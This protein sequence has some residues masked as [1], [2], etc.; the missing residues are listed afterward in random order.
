MVTKDPQQ[1]S[2]A[3]YS[4]Q[5]CSTLSGP[6]LSAS[7]ATVKQAGSTFEKAGAPDLVLVSSGLLLSPSYSGRPA[8]FL[9]DAYL[10]FRHPRQAQTLIVVLK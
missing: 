9:T 7:L 6:H 8:G 4:S 1:R 10:H 3:H 5:K 2:G